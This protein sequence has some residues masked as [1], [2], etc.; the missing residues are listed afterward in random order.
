MQTA[1]GDQSNYVTMDTVRDA[2]VQIMMMDDEHGA[3]WVGNGESVLEVHKD[4]VLIGDFED[5]PEEYTGRGT[6]WKEIETLF[7]SFL[8]DKMEIVKAHFKKG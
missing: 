4:L 8:S 6:D 3:F 7:H 1:W 5:E 2:I